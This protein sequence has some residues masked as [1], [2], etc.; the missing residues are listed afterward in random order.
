MI[1]KYKLSLN[2][3]YKLLMCEKQTKIMPING[4]KSSEHFID[5]KKADVNGG[6]N[7]DGTDDH[8]QW[9]GGQKWDTLRYLIKKNTTKNESFKKW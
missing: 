1:Y 4:I 8:D 7:D 3:V 2:H 5:S 9:F 6:D